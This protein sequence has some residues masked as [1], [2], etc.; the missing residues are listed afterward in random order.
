MFTA[1]TG[2]GS[3]F[4]KLK[5]VGKTVLSPAASAVKKT[6]VTTTKSYASAAKTKA[7]SSVAKTQTAQKIIAAQKAADDYLAVSSGAKPTLTQKD[8]AKRLQSAL[9]MLGKI[10]GSASL[11]AIKVDGAIGAKTV[12]AVNLTFTKHIGPGQ[13]AAQYR[14]GK[15]PLAY[16]K[17]NANALAT[18]IEAE[19]KRRGGTVVQSVT[20]Q[21]A[22][23]AT[24][25]TKGASSF[26]PETAAAPK[27]SAKVMAS[28][29]KA[30]AKQLQMALSTLGKITGSAQLKAVKADGAIGP[31]TVAAVNWAFTKHLGAGQAPAQYR[32]GK[33]TIDTVKAQGSVLASLIESEIRRRGGSVVTKTTGSVK[34]VKT[35][36]G[37]KVKAQKVQT[38]SGE[39]YEVTDESGHTYYTTD[40]TNPEP[41]TPPAGLPA[42]TQEQ[43]ETAAEA[44][45]AVAATTGKK[46][47][48]S[49]AQVP[50]EEA[51]EAAAMPA[52]AMVRTAAQIAP[53][54]GGGSSGGESFFSQYKWPILGIGAVA[55][56]GAAV[57]IMKRR[58]ANTSSVSNLRRRITA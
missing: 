10:A 22:A 9:V 14:T 47:V 51:E 16:V 39:T 19:I 17:A 58:S 35:K 24:K 26:G 53:D 27:L 8:A 33:L 13:A 18:L 6:A 49:P 38:P 48:V 11:K 40:P 1:Y 44:S 25:A 21:K 32:T 4:S 28:N 54:E 41:P 45:A 46:A 57:V 34:T 3:V 37:G 12:T 15:L 30:S 7:L 55:A 42:P 36:T 43:A 31:K 20:T 5:S 50:S 29:V 23:A 2:L 56:I 52:A